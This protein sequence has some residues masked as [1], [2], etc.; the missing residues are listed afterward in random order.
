MTNQILKWQAGDLADFEAL[1]RQ[2]E[3]LVFRNAYLITGVKEEA[4]DVLQEV[5][6]S[7]WK[8]RHTFDP[9]KG[10]F[11]TWLNRITVNESLR[12]RRRKPP[13]ALS[14]ENIDIADTRESYEEIL[15][16]KMETES[17]IRMIN[18]LDGKHRAALVL[19]YFNELSYE[20]IA[21]TVGVPVGTVKSRI[22]Q[23]LRLLRQSLKNDSKDM[24]I[25]RR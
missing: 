10:K 1:F 11:S 18:C 6:V 13:A 24:V 14:L 2:Y 5:F 4:Q 15:A 3:R 21:Q 22:Y 12:S 25:E 8:F 19:R 16:A 17:V 9:Q 23:A 7:V 20:E